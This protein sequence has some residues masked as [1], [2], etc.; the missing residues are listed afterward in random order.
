VISSVDELDADAVEVATVMVAT[1][2]VL[3]EEVV[4]GALVDVEAVF[5]TL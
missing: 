1:V 4:G 5:L 2:A 3:V